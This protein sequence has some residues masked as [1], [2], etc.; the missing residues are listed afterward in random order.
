MANVS[1]LRVI[2]TLRCSE[3]ID[4]S[5]AFPSPYCLPKIVMAR[6]KRA[7]IQELPTLDTE[8]PWT[9]PYD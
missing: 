6:N 1:L 4:F 7:I 5:T 8:S 3:R 9:L 2:I